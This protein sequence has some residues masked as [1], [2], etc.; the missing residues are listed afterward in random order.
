MGQEGANGEGP[1]VPEKGLGLAWLR[2]ATR[3]L[4]P[5]PPQ[6]RLGGCES[7]SEHRERWLEAQDPNSDGSLHTSL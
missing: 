4:T 7:S 2:H 1:R 3:W 5:P 6:D